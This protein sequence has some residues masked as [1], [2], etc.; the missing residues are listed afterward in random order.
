M[1]RSDSGWAVDS[2]ADSR[3]KSSCFDCQDAQRS[4][5]DRICFVILSCISDEVLAIDLLEETEDE[6]GRWTTDGLDSV[7][8]GDDMV[9]WMAKY[10]E[11]RE[12]D[13]MFVS[14]AQFGK[15]CR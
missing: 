15:I 9:L 3:N 12:G 7:E 5:C 1:L 11:S 14:K 2:S 6:C 13:K 4:C 10:R 8:L